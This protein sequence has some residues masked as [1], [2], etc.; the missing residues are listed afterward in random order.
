MLLYFSQYFYPPA[1]LVGQLLPAATSWTS[2]G[3]RCLPFS[4][5]GTRLHFYR[6]Q[7]FAA[8]P[9]FNLFRMLVD[10]HRTSP[11]HALA[12]SG[13]KKETLLR[14]EPTTSTSIVTRLTIGQPGTP[15]CYS[16]TGV[17]HHIVSH[18]IVY[19][20]ACAVLRDDNAGF[21]SPRTH[22]KETDQCLKSPQ[23]SPTFKGCD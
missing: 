12:F 21:L 17:S 9:L 8:F 20:C 11:T 4:P 6:A 23:T 15:D 13:C 3:R 22:R 7:G 2:R 19:I 1:Q 5:A 16:C 14:F 18:H 10:L